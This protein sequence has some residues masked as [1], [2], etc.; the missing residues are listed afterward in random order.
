[1]S[2][3]ESRRHDRGQRGNSDLLR[4]ISSSTR[5]PTCSSRA[6]IKLKDRR[7]RANVLSPGLTDTAL[8]SQQSA[9]V[10]ARIVS[11]V[12]IGCIGQPEEI[13]KAAVKLAEDNPR[14]ETGRRYSWT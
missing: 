2:A 1:M 3:G 9:D 8:E 12:P 7:I 11:T 6:H 5:G 14:I 10:I 4:Q 13:A